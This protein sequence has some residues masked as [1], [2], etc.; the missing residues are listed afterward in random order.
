MDGAFHLPA[1]DDP[2]INNLQADAARAGANS[3]MAMDTGSG[4]LPQGV[5][6]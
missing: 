4:V 3:P 5:S 6:I 2:E 1:R